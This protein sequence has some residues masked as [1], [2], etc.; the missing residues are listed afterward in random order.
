MIY[1]KRLAAAILVFVALA[2]FLVAF[3]IL[4][5]WYVVT[6]VDLSEKLT[7][8]FIGKQLPR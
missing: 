5:I 4:S 7:K 3:P 2:S 8:Y 1:F 6:G